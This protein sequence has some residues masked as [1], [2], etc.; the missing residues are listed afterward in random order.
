MPSNSRSTEYFWRV[1]AEVEW[2]YPELHDSNDIVSDVWSFTTKPNF[3]AG[4]NI[5]TTTALAA[6][7]F[8]LGGFAAEGTTS[9]NW[10][11]F[12][13]AFGGGSTT[14]VTFTD[15][16]DPDTTVIISEAGK[17][18]LTLTVDGLTDSKEIVVIDDA[19]EAAKATG[20][21]EANYYDRD[22]DC[23]VD[24][25]DFSIFANSFNAYGQ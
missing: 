9:I 8:A 2:D 17:Y 23:D 4:D 21:W 25:K 1:V 12:D 16:T 5:L 6:V 13:L 11:A 20:T 18:I 3:N 15:A 10:E 22:D 7:P 19:C 14:K 24:L